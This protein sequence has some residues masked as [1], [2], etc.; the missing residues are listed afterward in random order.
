MSDS[1]VL[2]DALEV[3]ELEK[4]SIS[5]GMFMLRPPKISPIVE[6]GACI[7]DYNRSVSREISRPPIS[8]QD[9]NK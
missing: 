5:G 1:T 3:S 2:R 4:D 9:S 8:T 7:E 6:V